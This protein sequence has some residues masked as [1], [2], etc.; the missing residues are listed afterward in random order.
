MQGS[1]DRV[2]DG[3]KIRTLLEQARRLARR[4]RQCANTGHLILAAFQSDRQASVT[5]S[6]MGFTEESFSQVIDAGKAND[7][8]PS[9]M[10]LAVERAA[11]IANSFGSPGVGALHLILAIIRDPRTTGS[12]CLEDIGIAAGYA[13]AEMMA[14]LQQ[15][16]SAADGGGPARAA[17]SEP[18]KGRNRL[19]VQ[20][21]LSAK[22]SKASGGIAADAAELRGAVLSGA[23]LQ[24]ADLHGADLRG[25]V[26]VDADLRRAD[27]S[28]ANLDKAC[29]RGA[30]LSGA[31]LTGA[32][33]SGADLSGAI[34]TDCPRAPSSQE[35]TVDTN[36][37][38]NRRD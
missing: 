4:K 12:R 7:E 6:R 18:F 21:A 27:L 38:S 5:L 13:A 16:V 1:K 26:L 2:S 19:A 20:A 23:D 32:S 25:A 3:E 24:G 29:L 14:V 33:L 10:E 30:N 17:P 11:K 9:M 8:A 28:G 35:P 22:L 34:L 36:D 15:R 31:N 37:K